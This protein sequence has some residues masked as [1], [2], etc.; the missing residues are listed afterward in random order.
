MAYEKSCLVCGHLFQK[1]W[2]ESK[3]F[4]RIRHKYCSRVCANNAP[5]SESTRQKMRLQKLGKSSWNKGISPSRKT[6][7]L[8]SDALKGRK[9]S[10]DTKKKMMGRRPWNKIGDGVTSINERIRKSSKYKAWR[11]KV[12]ERDDYT[13]KECGKRGG[14]LHA[15]HKKPFALY[16][17]IRFKVSNGVTLCIPCH[18]RTK[19]FGINQWTT[20]VQVRL[21]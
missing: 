8:L 12:F 6:R 21:H 1:P 15:H 10:E 11:K 3:R 14:N 13:C 9:L 2:N 20:G 7:K 19:S 4:W 5:R 18:K 17:E 16:I